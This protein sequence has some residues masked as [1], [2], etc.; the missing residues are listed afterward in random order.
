MHA[1][2]IYKII[3]RMH[4]K[5]VKKSQKKGQFISGINFSDLATVF[6]KH[7]FLFVNIAQL[8]SSFKKSCRDVLIY[9]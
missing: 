9:K 3:L 6:K 8:I 5:T 4:N 7:P 1:S 2:Q